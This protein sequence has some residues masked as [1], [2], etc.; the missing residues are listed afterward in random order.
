[1]FQTLLNQSG[2]QNVYDMLIQRILKICTTNLFSLFI[3]FLSIVLY[4]K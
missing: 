2:T 3:R 1:M 4:F